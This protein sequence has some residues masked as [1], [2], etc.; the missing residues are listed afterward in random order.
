MVRQVVE[1]AT[2]SGSFSGRVV[3]TTMFGDALLPR[4]QEIAVQDLAA[5]SAPLGLNERLVRTSLHRLSREQLVTAQRRGRMSFYRVHPDATPVFEEANQRI[6]GKES[7][8]EPWD[9]SWTIGVLD[10]AADR[11]KRQRVLEE[12]SWIGVRA[13]TS[14]V[15]ASPTIEPNSIR[16]VCE[17]LDVPLT[18]LV[19]GPLITGTIGADENRL[20]HLDPDGRLMHM[21][22]AHRRRFEP[23]SAIAVKLEPRDAFIVRTLLIDSWRRVAL[24]TPLF[25]VE[26]LPSDWLG[27]PMYNLTKAMHADMFEASERYLDERLGTAASK[28]LFAPH[29]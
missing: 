7:P 6:Y 28:S 13:I 24:A 11:A 17:R 14:D 8:S 10:G 5:L 26:L 27:D 23:I 3:L 9:G 20:R 1:A 15:V 22:E 19:R 21:L 16:L 25:P 2:E 18:A 12:L 4:S 29:T